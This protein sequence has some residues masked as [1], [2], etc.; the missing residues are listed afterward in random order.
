[1]RFVARRQD[2]DG[3]CSIIESDGA[4]ECSIIVSDGAAE[5]SII[6][7]DGA[8]ECSIIVPDGAAETA[9]NDDAPGAV[10]AVSAPAVVRTIARR[11]ARPAERERT[12]VGLRLQ[13]TV[14]TSL[15]RA[16]DVP[17]TV[18]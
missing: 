4:A 12:M 7:S 9:G 10:H 11:P 17:M 18:P 15:L 8:A 1:M 5:C 6:E 2:G 3:L 14:A 16:D 13:W